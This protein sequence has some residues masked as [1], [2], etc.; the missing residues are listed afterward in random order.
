ME[1]RAG[2]E[3][4]SSGWKPEVFGQ[5]DERCENQL[6]PFSIKI[7]LGA[8]G[9]IVF[10][11]W[12]EES[13]GIYIPEG[14]AFARGTLS[15]KQGTIVT[16]GPMVIFEREPITKGTVLMPGEIIALGGADGDDIPYGKPFC[17]FVEAYY[18]DY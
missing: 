16:N 14:T 1:H 4:A 9:P 3:P 17:S 5:L 12:I 6:M 8:D 10:E 18:S 15:G 13:F 2:F 11:E 7:N